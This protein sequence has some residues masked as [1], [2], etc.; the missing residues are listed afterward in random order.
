MPL[1][2]LVF[3]NL[4]NLISAYHCCIFQ[5]T[6]WLPANVS[7]DLQK[8]CKK[9]EGGMNSMVL[10]GCLDHDVRTSSEIGVESISVWLESSHPGMNSMV[11]V[12]CV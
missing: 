7:G 2:N 8:R 3:W 6:F 12:R 4:K 1:Q 9:K 5:M 10:L 11:L